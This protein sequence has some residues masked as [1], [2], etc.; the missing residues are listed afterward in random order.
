M[1]RPSNTEDRTRR[2]VR[3]LLQA[4]DRALAAVRE[5]A[6]ARDALEREALRKPRLSIVPGESEDGHGE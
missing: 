4:I 2:T 3:R 6:A 5:V 1:N